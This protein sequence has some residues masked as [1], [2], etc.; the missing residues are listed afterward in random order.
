MEMP[1]T[2]PDISATLLGL[3]G[4]EVPRTFEGDDLSERLRKGRD[5][6]N[7]AV[8]YMGVAPFSMA[9]EWRKPYRAVKTNRYT[10]VRSLEGPWLLY[11]DTSDPF[12]M[13]NLVDQ[14]EY[15]SLRNDLDD[16]LQE[17]LKKIGDDFRAPSDYIAEWGYE[18]NPRKGN[19]SPKLFSEHAQTPERQK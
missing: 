12:Q 4:L 2:T 13:N 6:A 1:L 10:Y 9:K 3:A 19:I 7:H 17:L 16:R 5:K 18:V 14:P 11:D 15:A 8:L